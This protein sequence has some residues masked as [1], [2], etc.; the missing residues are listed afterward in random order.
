MARTGVERRRVFLNIPYDPQPKFRYLYIAY[1]VGVIELGLIP[2]ATLAIEGEA[3]L[4]RIFALIKSSRYSIHDLSCVK[5]DR[6]HPPTPRF[7]MPFELG[8]AVAWTKE[9]PTAHSFF[10]FE[11][12][13]RRGHKST[14]DMSGY[15]FYIHQGKPERVMSNL[16]DA[17]VRKTRSPNVPAMMKHYE[18]VLSRLP[19]I[20]RACG[21]SSI[22]QARVFKELVLAATEV[23][24]ADS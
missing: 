5:I 17:F 8:L 22:F 10:A 16:C 18:V 4:D 3:R 21:A 24:R 11:E 1:I 9:N 12:M 23:S 20:K 13:E 19:E 7:N 2:T 6:K 15:D 14:S